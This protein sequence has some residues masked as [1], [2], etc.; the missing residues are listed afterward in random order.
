[1]RLLR[2]NMSQVRFVFPC[3]ARYRWAM[4]DVITPG[5]FA[6]AVAITFGAGVV[7]GA[8]GFAMPLIMIALMGLYLPPTVVVAAII[9]PIV[10]SNAAQVIRFGRGQVR[11]VVHE[12]R[13]YLLLVCAMILASAQ[14][15]PRMSVET[16]FLVIG[17]PVAV[18]CAV[19]LA[20]VRLV[21]PP[22]ARPA[23]SWVAGIVSGAIGG[24]AGTWG[25]PTI[26][27]LM[28]LETP[29]A[30][31]VLAQGIIYFAGAV[32]LFVGHVMSG[33]MNGSTAPLSLAL[34]VPAF[35]GLQVGFRLHDRI[36]QATFRKA[37]L[38]VLLLVAINLIRKGLS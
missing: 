24:L 4:F 30:K 31:Q 18:L 2:S 15:L 33:V 32:T 21:L 35:A 11:A 36:D 8:V 19:Q 13:V 29:K 37:T 28:A 26:L 6:L 20:G 27:Y 10:L 7:K 25:P 23:A 12:F 38:W 17:L 9:L 1:M 3:G 34:V 16:V 14:F 5:E 22:R